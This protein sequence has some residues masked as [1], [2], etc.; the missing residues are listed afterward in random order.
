MMVFRRKDGKL[1]TLWFSVGFIPL[2][3][4]IGYCIRIKKS[5]PIP[6]IHMYLE[7]RQCSLNLKRTKPLILMKVK[8]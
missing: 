3:H 6:K 7:F 2:Q 4:L 1:R 5:L 8:N